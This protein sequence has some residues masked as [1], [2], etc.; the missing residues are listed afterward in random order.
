MNWLQELQKLH[1]E[2]PPELFHR[3]AVNYNLAVYTFLALAKGL[4]NDFEGAALQLRRAVR[5]METTRHESSFKPV[6]LAFV[7][8]FKEH[9]A[10][11]Y[12]KLSYYDGKAPRKG[13][14]VLRWISD[15]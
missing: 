1:E 7:D 6:V 12:D 5:H 11:E 2:C 14:T 8:R 9:Y 4:A 15:D 3:N 13:K 10:A